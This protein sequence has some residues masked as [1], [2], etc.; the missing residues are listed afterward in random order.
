MEPHM[1]A[2]ATSMKSTIMTSM[3]H[4]GEVSWSFCSSMTRL[5]V[6]QLYAKLRNSISQRINSSMFPVHANTSVPAHRT[7]RTLIFYYYSCNLFLLLKISCCVTTRGGPSFLI[8]ECISE[9][10]KLM[11][12]IK[13]YWDQMWVLKTIQSGVLTYFWPGFKHLTY[14]IKYY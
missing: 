10:I 3:G 14:R 8:K 12:C 13:V 6:S 7:Q 1:V 9:I 11:G 5:P 4:K 2:A